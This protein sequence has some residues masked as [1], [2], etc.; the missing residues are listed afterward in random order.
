MPHGPRQALRQFAR[1]MIMDFR[2]A[3]T[4]AIEDGGPVRV[5]FD[6]GQG[7]YAVEATV[8]NQK[9]IKIRDYLKDMRVETSS[10]VIVFYPDG[11]ALP[12]GIKLFLGDAAASVNNGL[13]RF[14]W[15]MEEIDAVTD[16]PL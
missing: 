16:A 2:L 1:Q 11:S 15:T 3:Q 5:T 4:N 8:P 7:Q 9:N 12:A 14:G 13:Y 10:E 6:A